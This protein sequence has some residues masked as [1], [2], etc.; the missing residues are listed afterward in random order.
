MSERINVVYFFEAVGLDLVKIGTSTNPHGRL[1]DLESSSP[2]PLRLLRT[3]AGGVPLE[4]DL[5]HRFRAH[6]VRGEWFRLAPISPEI[7]ALG[8]VVVL[9]DP[10]ACPDCGR[11]RRI[12]RLTSRIGR[13]C[14]VCAG[15]ARRAEEDLINVPCVGCGRARPR[16][17]S[18][19]AHLGPLC[20]PCG[21]RKAWQ[22]PA[23]LESI[24]EA[25]SSRRRLCKR[26]GEPLEQGRGGAVYHVGC[27]LPLVPLPTE[28]LLTAGGS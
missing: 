19:A 2:V 20:R 10:L 11:R 14:R 12:N 18:R 4:R 13:R 28:G 17:R 25:R 22:T 6:R 5:H 27:Y 1:A 9:R 24:M 7:A 23:Y 26:C 15:K 3:I 16:R 8:D 21:M